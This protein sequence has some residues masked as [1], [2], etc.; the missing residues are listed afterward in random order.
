MEVVSRVVEAKELETKAAGGRALADG[1][2]TKA[3]AQAE[4]HLEVAVAVAVKA[5]K[6]VARTARMVSNSVRSVLARCC[7]PRSTAVPQ[8]SQYSQYSQYRCHRAIGKA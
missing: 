2:E 3:E 8:S 5:G 7:N 6:A 1:A 4:A